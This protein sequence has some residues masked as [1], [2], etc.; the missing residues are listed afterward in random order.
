[1]N[2]PPPKNYRK[3]SSH[4]PH[5]YKTKWRHSHGIYEKLNIIVNNSFLKLPRTFAK[6]AFFTRET[7]PL[8]Y[9]YSRTSLFPLQ[10]TRNL[11]SSVCN[12]SIM[13]CLNRLRYYQFVASV[14]IGYFRFKNT[15]A[16]SGFY[17][18]VNTLCLKSPFVSLK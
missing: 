14:F 18:P 9:N 4:Y 10:N 1:M 16:I 13:T 5:V 3:F 6:V 11:L 12:M 17:L 15:F 7:W 8:N 2:L